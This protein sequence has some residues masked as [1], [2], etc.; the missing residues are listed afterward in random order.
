MRIEK[1]KPIQCPLC[2]EYFALEQNVAARALHS[3][4]VRKLRQQQTPP[5]SRRAPQVGKTKTLAGLLAAAADE[6]GEAYAAVKR[7]DPGSYE[8][9]IE[10]GLER[11]LMI[12]ILAFAGCG[13]VYLIYY[14]ELDWQLFGLSVGLACFLYLLI[15]DKIRDARF[16][17]WRRKLVAGQLRPSKQWICLACLHSWRAPAPPPP[18]R[19]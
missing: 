8:W 14:F 9:E 19:T 5:A 3:K 15:S 18:R 11:I 13:V 16:E 7:Y 2:T 17:Q 12:G 10:P 1:L 6:E 4:A